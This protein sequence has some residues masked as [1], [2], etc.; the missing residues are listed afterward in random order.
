MTN[1]IETQLSLLYDGEFDDRYD[2]VN[3]LNSEI[4]IKNKIIHMTNNASTKQ[5]KNI[6]I[7]KQVLLL[8][9]ILILITLLKAIGVIPK[10]VATL[11]ICIIVIGFIVKIFIIILKPDINFN[12]EDMLTDLYFHKNKH[13]Q[14]CPSKCTPK[15]PTNVPYNIKTGVTNRLKTDSSLNS[16]LYGDQPEA[17]FYNPRLYGN[18]YKNYRV[19]GEDIYNADTNKPASWY[20]QITDN[21]AEEDP[22]QGVTYYNCIK[23]V[24]PV[25]TKQEF[26]TTIP[27]KYYPGYKTLNKCIY[28]SN[29]NCNIV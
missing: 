12:D 2:H 10:K 23:E 17:L 9:G 19:E 16:W 15:S 26:R 1:N 28:D 11:I 4:S 27:C 21:V 7:L 3:K 24:S 25:G 14:Q 18:K 13:V 5:I 22:I 29:D 20:N 8:A 6:G